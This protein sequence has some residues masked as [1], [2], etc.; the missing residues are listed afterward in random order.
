MTITSN[1]ATP[2]HFP[3]RKETN[4][5]LDTIYDCDSDDVFFI[6]FRK[7]N[8]ELTQRVATRLYYNSRNERRKRTNFG[9]NKSQHN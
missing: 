6:L 8:G 9:S 2:T 3:T 7:Q 1:F 4:K 5:V